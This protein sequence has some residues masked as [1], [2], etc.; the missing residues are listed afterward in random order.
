MTTI[1]DPV[2][3][4]IYNQ[5]RALKV[6]QVE[7]TQYDRQLDDLRARVKA[8]RLELRIKRFLGR[9][10]GGDKVRQLWAAKVELSRLEVLGA[11]SHQLCRK[12]DKKID[13]QIATELFH[14]DAAYR[15]M[16]EAKAFGEKALGE[17]RRLLGLVNTA[18]DK[19]EF[20]VGVEAALQQISHYLPW[21]RHAIDDFKKASQVIS[22]LPMEYNTALETVEHSA[23]F[24]D[25]LQMVERV[26]RTKRLYEL[27]YQ[28]TVLNNRLGDAVRSLRN[29]C[30]NQIATVRTSI[31]EK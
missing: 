18:R 12:L 24:S 1:I 25:F 21:T 8:L 23:D 26:Q 31:E 9:R 6:Q 10:L 15:K 13:D 5:L 4:E 30:N 29:E 3:S 27:R 7:C 16:Y 2:R 19:A 20:D 28:V 22:G 14:H 11:T 17:V